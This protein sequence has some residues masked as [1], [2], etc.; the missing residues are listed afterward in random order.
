MRV[1][2]L[3][4]G[5]MHPLVVG[6]LVA[7]VLLCEADDGLVLVDSGFGLQDVAEPAR[8]LGPSRHLLRA[9][10]APGHTAARQVEALGHRVEDVR[11]VVLTHLDLD[12]AGGL[13]DFPHA[14][15]HTTAA[16][17]RAATHPAPRERARYRRAQWAHGPRWRTYGGP[18]EPWEGFAEAYA[19]DGL[20][21]RFALVPMP[22]HSRGHA[23]VAVRADRPGGGSGWLVHA[24]DA[25]FDGSTVDPAVPRNRALL[26][27][28]QLVAL[29]RRAV[30][31]HHARLAALHASDGFEV[32]TA[33]DAA[34][35]DR[36][37]ADTGV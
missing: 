14:V 13:A 19:L 21:E 1:H 16:E 34:Q 4:C 32:V 15:V 35:L 8:R 26:A 30:A 3:D 28:E 20:D 5:P 10:L 12:H 37:R 9:A 36:R 33:H 25:A 29:D 11:H 31:D 24:G 27:F 7:H 23:A 2:S 17:H 18:G 22:G 6:R